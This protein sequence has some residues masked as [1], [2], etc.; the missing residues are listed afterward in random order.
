MIAEIISVGAE[1]LMGNVINTNAAFLSEEC[2][3]L[4]LSCYNQQVVGD[5]A[6]R[7]R[8]A[9]ELALSRADV[10]LVSGGLGP[11]E[12]DLTKETAA[13]LFG[14][15]LE[16]HTESKKI[17]E[18]YFK[19]K[20]LPMAQSNYKQIMMPRGAQV[21]PNPNG[22]APG[23]ILTRDD[24]HLILMP[25]PPGEMKPMFKDSVK[26]YL[27]G[28]S[29]GTIYSITV[30]ETGIGES[31]AEE[32]ILD[33]IDAQTNP[34]IATY[35]KTGE[36][37]FRVSAYGS[38]AKEAKAI[39][40]PVAKEIVRRFKP[41]VYATDEDVT[42]EQSIVIQLAKKKMTL[43]CAE[44]CTGGLLSGRIISVPG[45]SEVYK[46]GFVTYANKA[47]RKLL[48]VRK[49]TLRQYGAVSRECAY[50]MAFGA[51]RAA[52]ADVALSVTGIAGPDGGT[53]EKPV[54][55]VFIGCVVKGEAVVKEYHFTGNRE[56]IA[57]V[58]PDIKFTLTHNDTPVFKLSKSNLKQRI[59]DMFSDKITAQLIPLESETPLVNIIGYLGKPETAK[60]KGAK[61]FFFVNGRFMKHQYFHAAVERAFDSIIPPGEHVNYFIYLQVNP[62]DI[63]VNVHPTKTEIKFENE[64]L[65]WQV[66]N[67]VVRESI[68]R[69]N[70]IPTI[71]FNRKDDDI[72]I[73]AMPTDGRVVR[74][75]TST[76]SYNPFRDNG[77]AAA[78]PTYDWE[79]L[80]PTKTESSGGQRQEIIVEGTLSNQVPRQTSI[81]DDTESGNE[82]SG[83]TS[84]VTPKDLFQYRERYVVAPYEGGII[85]IDQHRAHVKVLFQEY[86]DRIQHQ[87]NVTQGL[88]F[89]E[90]IQLNKQE[91]A[92]LQSIDE[93]VRAVGFDVSSL[94][95][96]AYSL[97]GVP[98]GL[99]GQDYDRLLH[100]LIWTAMDSKAAVKQGV[101]ESIAL[102]MAQSA[103]VCY[104]QKLGQDEMRHLID[105]LFSLPNHSRTPDGKLIYGVIDDNFID[106]LF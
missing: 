53:E 89:P 63:D 98:P 44:S 37:H 1:I 25:G 75:T 74:M 5:N 66:L 29:G 77:A 104:G 18:S 100:N 34:T 72:N 22:T 6:A 88:L 12:D 96:G 16:E 39:A 67:A 48:G 30:K 26:P 41:Y 56:R 71:D 24:K 62:Q 106:R 99:E 94:G 4:G 15:P 32:M 52:E 21:I 38:N 105:S 60:R 8:S 43:T 95:G 79:Q 84:D 91:D 50:E 86:M 58:Y 85:V 59:A 3:S 76:T 9:F 47:K 14:V 103:A 93:D 102:A 19:A 57:L 31:R 68:G 83:A 70:E 35:A 45:V 80:Y 42:L 7:L 23:V 36:V 33:L 2:V 64:Q 27:A 82:D 73:P 49:K 87:T 101:S 55:T 20:N 28:L 11:T 13:E 46:S 78:R 40:K 51:A 65:L 92:V 17:L 54:G 69:Y 61:Q 90:I 10:V 97:N 81:W